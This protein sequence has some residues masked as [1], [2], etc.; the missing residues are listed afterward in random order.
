M[1]IF[2]LLAHKGNNA[3]FSFDELLQVVSGIVDVNIYY[4]V[5]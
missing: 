3:Y 2:N 1:R 5:K 4:L